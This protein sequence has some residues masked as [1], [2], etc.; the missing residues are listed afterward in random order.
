VRQDERRFRRL[1]ETLSGVERLLILTHDH[2]DPDALAAAFLLRRI[3]RHALAIECEIGYGGLIGRAEN[4]AMVA[5]LRIP[6]RPIGE[7][8]GD[9]YDAIALVDTQPGTPN[10]SLP[11]DRSAQIVFD[12]HP[13][14]RS[15]REVPF[16]DVRP[17][18]GAVA[19]MLA[20][21]LPAAG[22]EADRRLATAIF[23]AI[24]SETQNLGRESTPA[25]ARL[26]A[27]IFGTVDNRL[28]SRIEQAPFTRDY[29]V[30]LDEALRATRL[31]GDVAITPLQRVPYPDVPA[32][33][34]DLL[35]RVDGARAV[36]AM[37]GHR[38]Q[39]YLSLRTRGTRANAGRLLQ[40]I[41][42]EEGRAGGHGRMAGGRI[43]LRAPRRS[44]HAA[45][46]RLTRR[47]RELLGVTAQRA[48]PLIGRRARERAHR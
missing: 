1:V 5:E 3:A 23:Y 31:Y 39:L 10:H 46:R 6:V 48:R 2:P 8:R 13:Q 25:D 29:V 28:L 40:R 37:G 24:R 27:E 36:L 47:A 34:A 45:A 18:Y 15:T 26:F 16:S 43:D 42:G 30:I 38:G 20:E 35:L 41:V 21:Y 33:L 9:R 4:R 11:A 14:R 17:G 19:T 22:L 7:V 12:H 32:E 44:W